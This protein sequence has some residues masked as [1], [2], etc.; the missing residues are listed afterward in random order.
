MDL[1]AKVLNVI[2]EYIICTMYLLTKYIGYICRAKHI[3]LHVYHLSID[4]DTFMLYIR[5]VT[6]RI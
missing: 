2:Y 1:P 5:K 4:T 6:I 3:H